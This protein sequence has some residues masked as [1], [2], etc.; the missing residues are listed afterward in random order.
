MQEKTKSTL[1]DLLGSSDVAALLRINK[2]TV[3][4]I[5]ER[6]KVGMEVAGRM[7]FSSE[8]VETIRQNYQGGPG[9]P[10]FKKNI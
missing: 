7:L 8:D 2:T 9:N 10:N 1:R 5:A 6:C 3:L 4:R